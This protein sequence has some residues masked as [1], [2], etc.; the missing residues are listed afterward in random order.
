MGG[1]ARDSS[2][3][4]QSYFTGIFINPDYHGMGIGRKLFPYKNNIPT[5]KVML[6]NAGQ[7]VDSF[8]NKKFVITILTK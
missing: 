6:K 4:S 3:E 7:I 8:D 2:Q 5:I 1:V